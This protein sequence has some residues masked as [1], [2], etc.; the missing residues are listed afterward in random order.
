LW[1]GVQ[2]CLSERAALDLKAFNAGSNRRRGA[3]H[4][5]DS[6]CPWSRSVRA[7]NRSGRT[8]A[9]LE[10]RLKLS[11][12]SPASN[13]QIRRSKGVK[14]SQASTAFKQLCAIRPCCDAWFTC[15]RFHVKGQIDDITQAA[16]SDI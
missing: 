1:R 8:A 2:L 5:M 7:A 10:I 12:L 13:R 11:R 15:I 4:M 6:D 16:D 14:V 3:A 9:K